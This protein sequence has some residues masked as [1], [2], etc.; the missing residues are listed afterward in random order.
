MTFAINDLKSRYRNSILGL[1]WSFLEPLLILGILY[2]VF[3]VVLKS[4]IE[5]FPLYLL[6]GLIIWGMISKGTM[7]GLNSILQRGNVINKVSIPLEIP[8]ISSTITSFI[9]MLLEFV[10]LFIFMAVFRFIPPLQILLLPLIWL[11]TAILVLGISFPLSV[12]NIFYRDL[13]YLWGVVIT[14]GFFLAP[15]IYEL[16]TFPEPLRFWLK[17]NP[18]T[19]ILSIG[20]SIVLGKSMPSNNEIVYTLVMAFLILAIGYSIFKHYSSRVV[21]EI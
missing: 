10:I 21:E 9:T 13:Q 3:S 8:V 18:V 7:A 6:L 14:G 1:L 15:I 5:N 20:H 16:D 2:V 4:H 19:G 17:L 12:L 11:L